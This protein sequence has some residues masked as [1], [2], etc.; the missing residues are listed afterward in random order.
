MADSDSDSDSSRDGHDLI[1]PYFDNEYNDD[2]DANGDDDEEVFDLIDYDSTATLG[3]LTISSFSSTDLLST[4]ITSTRNGD[5]Q[6]LSTVSQFTSILAQTGIDG[7]RLLKAVNLKT[8]AVKIG[9]GSQFTVYKDKPGMGYMGNEGLV[10][11]RVNVP[12]SYK[13]GQRFAA[14]SE[15]RL[16][17]RTLELELLALG[18]PMLR[19]NRNIVSLVAWGYD[20]PFADTPVPVLFMEAAIM[21]LSD[22]LEA[23][24]EAMLGPKP[25]DVKYQLG[26]DIAN[27]LEALHRLHIVHGDV[28]PDNVLIFQ[29]NNDKV[30]FCAKLSDFGVCVDMDAPENKLTINDYRGTPAWIAP[31]LSDYNEGK[32]GP[33][34]PELMLRFDAYSFGLT[35]L[36]IFTR[37]GNPPE[38]GKDPSAVA[39]EAFELLKSQ[40]GLPPLIRSTINSAIRRLLTEDPRARA[41]PS[42]GLLKADNPAFASWFSLSQINSK[43]VPHVGTLDPMYNKGP[44]FWYRLDPTVLF[45]LES[46]YNLAE[47][48]DNHPDFPGSV[49]FGMAQKVIGSKA[50]HLDG[51]LRY[52]TGASK[53]G[54]SPARAVYAQIMHAHGKEPEF[55]PAVLEEWTLQAVSEGYFFAHPAVHIS[56]DKIEKA[57]AKFR[58]SG[59]FCDDPFGRKIETLNIARDRDKVVKWGVKTGKL[60]DTKGNTMLHVAAAIGALDSVRALVEI[61]LKQAVDVL[62]DNGETPLYKACQAGH[63]DVINYLLDHGA[64]ASQRTKRGMLSPLHWLF[65]IPEPSI[66]HIASRLIKTDGALVNATIIPTVA[67]NSDQ[68]GEKINIFHYP[69]ELPHGTPLHW[70]CFFRNTTAIDTLIAL[71]ANINATYHGSDESTTP[72]ALTAWFSESDIASLLIG[73][74]ANGRQQDAKGRNILHAVTKYFPD[75]HGYLAHDWHY[76]IRH[77]NWEEHRE[78]MT[79]LVRVLVHEGG[80]E[81]DALDKGRPPLSPIMAAADAGVWDAGMIWAL[82]EVGADVRQ[83]QEGIQDTVLHSWASTRGPR[84]AYPQGYIGTFKKIVTAMDAVDIR[85]LYEDDTPL[86]KLATVY[87][88]A[89]EFEECCRVL[90]SHTQPAD[91]N[92]KTSRG[93]TPLLI[94]LQGKWDPVRRGLFLLEKGAN[95][96][97]TMTDG[98]DVF[99]AVASNESLSDQQSHDLMHQLLD[100]VDPASKDIRQTYHTHFLN[101]NPAGC[102]HALFATAEKGK[103]KTTLLVL[104]LGLAARINELNPLKSPPITALDHALSAA[105]KSRREHLETLATRKHGDESHDYHQWQLGPPPHAA[106]AFRNF[107]EL[108]RVLRSRGAKCAWELTMRGYLTQ[109][110]RGFTSAIFQGGGV[111]P[112]QQQPDGDR[113]QIVYDLAR[114]PS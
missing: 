58:D 76:W 38:L 105:E 69:F 60:I 72:L 64:T 90:L 5:A 88:P 31:E 30:P 23:E 100:H 73:H 42:A 110:V 52:L 85:G 39:K 17:L 68:F 11:K 107:P 67:V 3:S 48:D 70:A 109:R 27:G 40:D 91:I 49:L 1:N 103:L 114:Y 61:N 10:I 106:E 33:F 75:R 54:F 36:S 22:F 104:D 79:A 32:F 96:L 6:I 34:E 59:G 112:A 93:A 45:E 101:R 98:K 113:W 94:A 89:D 78:K 95:P 65:M 56:A 66:E 111:T 41:L 9:A 29:G 81:I 82:L 20:F 84:I 46:Q 51:L 97:L 50:A 44:L 62:N 2:D 24:N 102:M 8:R 99:F 7:P 47:N 15:Y 92:K 43:S 26:L 83:A 80:A 86:Q 37:H 55:E 108:V 35:L 74:G 87:H 18:N 14:G 25:F 57:K 4:K 21:S 71:G 28:K 53:A 13:Q 19:N 77:G 63:V 16:Q 12:I